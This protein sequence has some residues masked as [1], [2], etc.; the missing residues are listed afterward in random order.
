[1]RDN[2]MGSNADAKRLI[3]LVQY[4]EVRKIVDVLPDNIPYAIVKGAPL[5]MLA[6]NSCFRRKIGDVDFLVSRESVGKV[7]QVLEENGFHTEYQ[8]REDKLIALMYSH[9]TRPFVKNTPLWKTYIDVNYDI[10]WGEYE[11][12]RINMDEFLR[13]SIEIEV[14]GCRVKTLNPLKTMIQL[15]LHHYKEMNS[16]YHLAIHNSI[17]MSMFADVYNLL[18]NNISDVSI[19]NLYRLSKE[20]GIVEYV[21]YV[22]FYTSE[23]FRDSILKKYVDCFRTEKG[24]HLLS[25]YGLCERERKEWKCDFQTR[26]AA[27]DLFSL[28]KDQLS[29]EDMEKINRNRLVFGEG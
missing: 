1:M 26:L 15:V 25:C 3:L 8:S 20:Y 13:D 17:T 19:D 9:Q 14:A 6:Y 7:T 22:L 5:S 10:F 16:L 11:G 2:N 29:L 28:I 23:L 18:K 4:D 27:K 12:K 24:E 21:F